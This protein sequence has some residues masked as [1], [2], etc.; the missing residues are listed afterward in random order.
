MPRRGVQTG[1]YTAVG[2]WFGTQIATSVVWRSQTGTM[3]STKGGLDFCPW[4][5]SAGEALQRLSVADPGV[6]LTSEEAHARLERDGPNELDKEPGKPLWKLV[7]EQFDDM[8]VKVL[9]AAAFI[10]FLLAFFEEGSAEVRASPAQCL[11]NNSA[12]RA[13]LSQ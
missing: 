13:H 3:A 11:R 2:V 7:L 1:A 9:L 4:T 6:G 12:G 10:S 8:L 5:V